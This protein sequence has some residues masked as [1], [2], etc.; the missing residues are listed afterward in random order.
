MVC[1]IC[2]LEKEAESILYE[3]ACFGNGLSQAYL[4]LCNNIMSNIIRLFLCTTQYIAA[5]KPKR[6][7]FGPVD[8]PSSNLPFSVNK[9]RAGWRVLTPPVIYSLEVPTIYHC[10]FNMNSPWVCDFVLSRHPHW[11]WREGGWRS[12]NRYW[13]AETL[14]LCQSRYGG[15][16]ITGMGPTSV[17]PDR[18]VF[19]LPP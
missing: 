12:P 1:N 2:V 11:L 17:S 8:T 18:Y 7:L 14:R 3:T 13:L 16:F 15:H 19:H 9:R 6:D 4:Q 10:K 5:V